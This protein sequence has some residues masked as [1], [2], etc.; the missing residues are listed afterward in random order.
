MSEAFC[1]PC[2]YIHSGPMS[3]S[4]VS[5]WR[6]DIQHVQQCWTMDDGDTD[7]KHPTV[8]HEEAQPVPCMSNTDTEE[9]ALWERIRRL[10]KKKHLASLLKRQQELEN[11]IASNLADQSRDRRSR[12][13]SLTHERPH[14]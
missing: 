14:Y 11:D 2:S 1:G 4:L 9:E 3:A 8:K 13:R 5:R 10:E 12:S 6:R 7:L